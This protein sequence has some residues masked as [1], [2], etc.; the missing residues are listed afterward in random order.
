M[1]T[2][3]HGNATKIFILPVD[4]PYLYLGIQWDLLLQSRPQVGIQL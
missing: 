4:G 3:H 2:M 1:D